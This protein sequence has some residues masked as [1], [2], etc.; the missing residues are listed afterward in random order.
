MTRTRTISTVA[1]VTENK[2]LQEFYNSVYKKGERGHYTQFRLQDGDW[3]EE[4]SAVLN[5][6]PWEGLSVMDAGCGTGDMCG[7]IAKAGAKAVLGVDYAEEAIKEAQEKYQGDNLTFAH[8]KI[9][10]V[11]DTFDVVISLGTLE[12]MDDPLATLKKFKSMLRDGGAIV[13]T[14]PNWLNPRGY[15]LQAL[16][17]MMRAPITL[18][19]IHYLTPLDFEQW[20]T[21][22][23][24]DLQWTTV[25]HEWGSG[26]KMVHDFE[27]RLPNV[28]RDA[29][30][31]TT[32]R[33]IDGLTQ[34][35][36]KRVVPFKDESK[37]AGA[38]GVYHL[39][40]RS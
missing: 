4:F 31:N 19:D 9:E 14:C 29:K 2:H 30:M 34:W 39:R 25:D 38:V 5:L 13:L 15:I 11:D 24:M 21:E 33:H 1:P 28:V 35:L 3:P 40:L 36:E 32:Q 27:R 18:A 8:Q 7:L 10:E 16:W 17:H 26:M 12:H 20:A 23:D 6:I 22:L 37:H